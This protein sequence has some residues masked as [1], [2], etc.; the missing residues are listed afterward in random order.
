MLILRESKII[1]FKTPYTSKT[2]M[3][4]LFFLYTPLFYT[5][6]WGFAHHQAPRTDPKFLE[7]APSAGPRLKSLA[8]VWPRVL[9][10][11]PFQPQD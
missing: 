3:K 10:L 11:C 6:L 2:L 5:Q 1:I 4:W 7:K 9:L 8:E